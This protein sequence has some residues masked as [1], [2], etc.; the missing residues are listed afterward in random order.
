MRT[1]LEKDLWKFK[2]ISGS[3]VVEMKISHSF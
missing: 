3:E 2:K 1:G